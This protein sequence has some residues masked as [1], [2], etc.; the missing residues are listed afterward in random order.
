MNQINR[1]ARKAPTN[2][3]AIVMPVA[4]SVCI[5]EGHQSDIDA[6]FT[7]MGLQVWC[8]RHNANVLHVDFEGNKHP[9]TTSR[10]H[11]RETS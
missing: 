2:Q 9:A 8:R 7:P 11:T 1:R 10:D 3:L 5:R 4:C 6:G